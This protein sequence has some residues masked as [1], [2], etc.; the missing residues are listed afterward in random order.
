MP[1]SLINTL[2][3]LQ[4]YINKI[5]AEKLTV[6]IIMYLN[7]ILIYRKSEKKAYVEAIW[8]VFDQMRKDWFYA[9]LKMWRFH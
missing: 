8:W 4:S 9:N 7:D 5:W 6:F 2:A 3:I 1:F